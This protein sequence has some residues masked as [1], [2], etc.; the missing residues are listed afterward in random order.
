M[1]QKSLT[2]LLAGLMMLVSSCSNGTRVINQAT[3]SLPGITARPTHTNTPACAKPPKDPLP[4][5]T[6]PIATV[7]SGKLPITQ[8]VVFITID[9]GYVIDD[10]VATLL[11]HAHI[12]FSLFLIDKVARDP[13]HLAFFRRLVR[14][15]GTIE[16][17]T[18][19][20][21]KLSGLPEA[22]QTVKICGP[23]DDYL[24]LFGERPTL[25]RPPFGS[26]DMTT[27]KVVRSCGLKAVMIWSAIMNHG[28]IAVQDHNLGAGE[29]ILMHFRTDLFANLT[30][31]LAAIR[32][33]HL[34]VGRLEDY[35]R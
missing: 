5:S 31:I 1:S 14:A 23:L 12:P 13:A 25:F 28:Y 6:G 16:D 35:V 7:W 27:R 33:R 3:S 18:L 15:G 29:V 10:R 8:C 9:D 17:H 2:R 30:Y 19:D 24:S 22:I 4:S 11:E 26:Y 34:T 20:H 21:T 32:W